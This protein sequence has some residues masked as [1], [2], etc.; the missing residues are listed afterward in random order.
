MPAWLDLAGRC[1]SSE[2]GEGDIQAKLASLTNMIC[3]EMHEV[4]G[5]GG[6]LARLPAGEVVAIPPG[7]IVV[8]VPIGDVK[9]HHA[10][11]R[12]STFNKNDNIAVR[13]LLVDMMQSY[14]YLENTDYQTVKSLLETTKNARAA[15]TA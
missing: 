8:T 9:D 5:K 2:L 3:P 4:V 7:L 13:S 15:E 14:S 1:A 10:V 11:V 12:Y 6:F